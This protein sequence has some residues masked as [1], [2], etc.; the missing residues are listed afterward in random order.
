MTDYCLNFQIKAFNLSDVPSSLEMAH[1]R[2]STPDYGLG[3]H[4][5]AL[6]HTKLFLFCS[7]ADLIQQLLALLLEALDWHGHLRVRGEDLGLRV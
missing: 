4:V 5:R 1:V 3:F 2:Q 6:K 7:E